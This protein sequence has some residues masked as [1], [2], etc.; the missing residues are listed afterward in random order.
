M[1][2]PTLE[3]SENDVLAEHPLAE[4][5]P[6]GKAGELK[7]EGG[8]WNEVEEKPGSRGEISLRKSKL[9]DVL[10]RRKKTQDLVKF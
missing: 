9:V 8:K 10:F 6:F 4:N 1:A 7:V 5:E 2:Q 3:N